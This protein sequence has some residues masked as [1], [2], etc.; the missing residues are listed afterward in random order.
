MDETS[1]QPFSD[2]ESRTLITLYQVATSNLYKIGPYNEGSTSELLRKLMD[3]KTAL[4]GQAMQYNLRGT[5][6]E[7]HS[8]III[9]ELDD[10]SVEELLGYV[11]FMHYDINPEIS[12][13]RTHMEVAWYVLNLLWARLEE[14]REHAFIYQ[15]FF[16]PW[17]ERQLTFP[18]I[19]YRRVIPKGLDIQQRG[20]DYYYPRVGE[21]TMEVIEETFNFRE[22][23]HMIMAYGTFRAGK[24][25][26]K[27]A[28]KDDT[29]IR[30]TNLTTDNAIRAALI[31]VIEDLELDPRYYVTVNGPTAAILQEPNEQVLSISDDAPMEYAK[32]ADAVSLEGI[33]IIDTD[34]GSPK[35][36]EVLFEEYTTAQLTPAFFSYPGDHRSVFEATKAEFTVDGTNLMTINV[37]NEVI[38][39]GLR[40]GFSRLRAY[41]MEH[42]ANT[43]ESMGDCYDPHS[44]LKY[45]TN[46]FLWRKFPRRAVRRLATVVLKNKLSHSIW[47]QKLIDACQLALRQTTSRSF[48]F[49]QRFIMELQKADLETKN[50]IKKAL[51]TMYNMGS[52]FLNFYE[53][54]EFYDPDSMLVQIINDPVDLLPPAHFLGRVRAKCRDMIARIKLHIEEIGSDHPI[55]ERLVIVKHWNGKGHIMYE[56]SSYT[57]GNFLDIMLEM[58]KLHLVKCLVQSGAWLMA[59]ATTYFQTLFGVGIVD[60]VLTF[61]ELVPHHDEMSGIT[62]EDVEEE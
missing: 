26:S 46:P 22:I 38:Y 50:R 29:L 60:S 12:K 30:I 19:F 3:L 5:I 1:E 23:L 11:K 56:D 6:A 8:A 49:Q 21:L 58:S 9:E 57:I 47:A 2:E 35:P 7:I 13:A 24:Y 44:I 55:F 39:Y 53:Q 25:K 54:V 4:R 32:L 48:E 61:E 34:D 14:L 31:I 28:H 62:Y 15:I 41:T 51:M 45:P 18:G 16:S 42:L 33:P 40:D 20:I 36:I 52:F 17:Y 37:E 10:F 59:T 43:F 27:M